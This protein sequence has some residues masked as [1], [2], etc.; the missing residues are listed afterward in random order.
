MLYMSEEFTICQSFFPLETFPL[1]M[2]TYY[3][4]HYNVCFHPVLQCMGRN[5]SDKSVERYWSQC[6]G[7]MSYDQ[8]CFVMQRE[9]RTTMSDLMKAFRKIDINGDGYITAKEL[10]RVLT[11]VPVVCALICVYTCTLYSLYL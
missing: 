2:Y 5:P 4:I 8:F 6:G 7:S 1:Y 3:G 11:K 9:K 10:H